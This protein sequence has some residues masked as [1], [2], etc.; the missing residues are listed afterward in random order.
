M[1]IELRKRLNGTV[2]YRAKVK[3]PD[4]KWYDSTTFD[5]EEDARLEEALLF[6][7]RRKGMRSVSQDARTVDVDGY[8]DVWSVE[9]RT[10]V[11]DGWKMSQDQMYR[12]YVRPVIGPQKMID[13]RKPEIGRVLS[14][15]KE[16]GKGEQMRK[17]VYSLLRKMFGDAVE[18]YEM[19]EAS[20]VSAKHHRPKVRLEKRDFLDIEEA[21]R[22]L[23]SVRDSYLGPPT[24]IM[25]LAGLRI[26][27]VQALRGSS[28]LFSSEQILIRAAFNNKTGKLQNHPKQEHWGYSQMPEALAEYLRGQCVAPEAL[29]APGPKGGI[30]SYETY[31]R[32]LAR[33]CTKAGVKVIT[34]HE[35]RHSCTGIW[36]EAGASTDDL[37]DLLNHGSVSATMRYIHRTGSRLSEVG[38][39]VRLSLVKG[40]ENSPNS[41]PFGER[42]K[43]AV[44]VGAAGV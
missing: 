22:L 39:K 14:R 32:A 19:L 2:G 24:W 38:K 3:D 9:N 4:G 29:V 11:S 43:S 41:S 27:E 30:L 34:P 23:R 16:M 28:L 20:P 21:S 13:V 7:K 1:A 31:L 10:D 5:N 26:S 18:Y 17:H 42:Q 37:R 25:M 33:E 44:P 6:D 12:D 8:W 35:L 15:M 36:A 40:N